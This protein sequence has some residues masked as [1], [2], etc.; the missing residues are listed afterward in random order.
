M[1][2]GPHQRI[3]GYLNVTPRQGQETQA[4]WARFRIEHNAEEGDRDVRRLASAGELRFRT[5]R[6]ACVQ[7]SYATSAGARYI[8]IACLVTGRRSES[9]I[10]AAAP[11]S[12]WA[13]VAPAMERAISTLTV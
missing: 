8:E 1:L 6:G 5:G 9:V 11:P 4:N 2:L 13:S 10:V 3:L 7:D 12:A